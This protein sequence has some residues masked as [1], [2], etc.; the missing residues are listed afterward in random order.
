MQTH[1]KSHHNT[2]SECTYV[3]VY[4]CVRVCV[5]VCVSFIG[6]VNSAAGVVFISIFASCLAN[7]A[8]V[9]VTTTQTRISPC[10]R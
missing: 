3:C 7:G 6:V 5:R 4:V 1:C 8:D 9:T 2:P 10:T